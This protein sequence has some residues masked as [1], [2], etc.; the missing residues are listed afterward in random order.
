M[1]YDTHAHLDYPEFAAELPAVVDR[2]KQAGVTRILTVGTDLDS[3]RRAL[4]IAETFPEVYAIVG[5]H[6]SNVIS[7]PNHV[8]REFPKMVDHP[9]VVAI[10]ETGLDYSRLPSKSG[11]TPEDD[12]LYQE[13]QR[14]LF[15]DQLD[16]AVQSGLNVV[17]HQR[18]ALEDTIRELEPYSQKVRTVFHC[19]VETLATQKRIA[20]LGSIVSFTGIVTFKNAQTVQETAAQITAEFMVE[21]DCPYL[22]PVPYR[23]KRCEPAYVADTSRKIAE[24]RHCSLDS[25]SVETCATAHKFF[26]K[27]K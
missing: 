9:K 26:P 24:L 21:T 16:L 13:K 6:P 11:G 12:K 10:G 17:I 18:D 1:F 20:T 15:R 7:A 22:A 25:L 5:W 19:F 2:A 8:A 14:K 4:E 23:G 27:L 3:S